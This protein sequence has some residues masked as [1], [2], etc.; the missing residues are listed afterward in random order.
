MNILKTE[1]RNKI[2][3]EWLN[4]MMICYIKRNVFETVDDEA[5]LMRFQNMQSRRI[6]FPPRRDSR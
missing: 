2:G 4:D 3:D 1:L 6:Q 5:T